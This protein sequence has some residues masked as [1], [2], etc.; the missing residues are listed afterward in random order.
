[1]RLLYRRGGLRTRKSGIL[2]NRRLWIGVSINPRKLIFSGP[3]S[4]SRR[5][6]CLENSHE[7]GTLISNKYQTFLYQVYPHV[8]DLRKAAREK[9]RTFGK[10]TLLND[11]AS[12]VAKLVFAFGL[13]NIGATATHQV[14]DLRLMARI[15]FLTTKQ[16]STNPRMRKSADALADAGHEVHV[17]YAFN[18]AWAT[19]ADQS[20]LRSSL[21]PR[22]S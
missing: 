19:E 22:A 16:P 2:P 14:Q 10:P 8:P 13:E 21:E 3:A 20:I 15:L 7:V 17:L 9:I 1:M 11:V 12:T 6:R 18:T 4:A 5:L